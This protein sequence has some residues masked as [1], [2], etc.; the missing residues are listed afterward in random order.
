MKG[1]RG[2]LLLARREFFATFDAPAGYLV[3]AFLPAVSAVLLFVT[4]PFFAIGSADLRPFFLSLPWL[5]VLL[6]PAITMRMWAEER[7]AGTE[8]LLLTW[9]WR[10][11]A[12]I[13]GK[14]LGAWAILAAALVATA[15]L[16]VSVSW[17]GDLDPGPV[18]GGYLG[19]LFLG[20]ACIALGLF[21]S[22]CTDNQ[23]VA[24]LGGAAV[25]L[26]VNLIGVG[27]T[28]EAVPGWLG[29]ILLAL[30][31]GHHFQD[32]ARGVVSVADLLFYGV[33]MAFFLALNAL[34]LMR[35]AWSWA[36]LPA[37]SWLG[38]PAA[39]RCAPCCCCCRRRSV[40]P[41]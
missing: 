22:A 13:L 29:R 41:A 37:S 4:G 35:R 16:V 39:V 36:P 10:L 34:V 38:V 6:A 21:L 8:E 20:G 5:F 14:F 19:A 18:L 31:F 2:S 3:L 9:P 30:D 15:G 12:L 24:W 28:A 7:R 26:A 17:L 11:R 25:L 27:A 1:F 32:L 23:I 40:S 33:M